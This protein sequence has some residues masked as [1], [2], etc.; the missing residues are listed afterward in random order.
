MTYDLAPVSAPRTAG[1]SLRALVWALEHEPARSLLVGTLLENAG[2]SA[3]RGLDPGAA[4]AAFVPPLEAPARRSAAASEQVCLA[5]FLATEVGDLPPVGGGHAFR[6]ARWLVRAYRE[7]ALTP[8]TVA[9]RALAAVRESDARSPALRVFISQQE[10]EVLSQ[11]RAATERYRG[12][13][14]L[15]PLDGVPVAVK[16]EIDQA[17]YPT[18]LGTVIHGKQPTREDAT[19]VA[20]LRAAGAVLLGKV[21]MHEI[22]MG[23][24]GLNPHHGACRNPWATGHVTGGSSS[25]SAAAVAAGFCPISVG[26]DGGGS[27]RIPAAFCGV[28][29]LKPTFSR[30]SEHGVAPVCSSVAHVGSFGATVR[31]CALGYALM[32]GPDAHDALSLRQPPVLLPDFRDRDLSGVRLGVFEAWFADAEPAVVAACRAGVDRLVAAGAV[33]VPIEIPEL[34]LVRIAHLVSIVSEMAGTQL[35]AIREG[36]QRFGLDTRINLALAQALTA[37]DY[38]HAQRHRSRL[39]GIWARNL[40]EVD[41]IV[42]P[43][44]GCTAPAYPADALP[45]GESNLPQ[46]VVIMRYAQAANLFGLPAITVPAGY[47][48][49]GLPIGLQLMGRAW[50]EALLLRAAAVVEAGV[51]RRKPG[52]WWDLGG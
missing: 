23:V 24:T 15:G 45:D 36:V 16:D 33:A 44:A 18:T 12:G 1:I 52:A 6:S 20:R 21:N 43:T 40:E 27:V 39:G 10:E 51:E 35:G 32:A 49:A 38:V 17:G 13:A 8:L 26:C 30:I 41:M 42:T 48:G 7:G 19:S 5:D 46:T 28:V 29:G 11:A 34:S 37:Q 2:V 50:E 25:G 14:P 4:S 22:G 31:D 9:E 47:D 3:L